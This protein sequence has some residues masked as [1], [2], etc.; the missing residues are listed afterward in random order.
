MEFVGVCCVDD[1]LA[2]VLGVNLDRLGEE[3]LRGQHGARAGMGG[4]AD[5]GQ[6]VRNE[7]PEVCVWACD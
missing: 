7:Q 1:L 6:E 3:G 5:D 4:V 2:G